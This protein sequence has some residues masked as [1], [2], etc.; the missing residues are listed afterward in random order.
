MRLKKIIALCLTALFL[1][2]APGCAS[3][4]EEDLQVPKQVSDYEVGGETPKKGGTLRLALAGAGSLN[5]ILAENEHTMQVLNLVYDSLFCRDA[6]EAL[7]PVLC[8]QYSVS[9]DGLTYEFT[10]RDGIG[11]HNGDTLSAQDVE[12]TIYMIL[13]SESLYKSKLSAISTC[14]SSGNTLYITLHNPVVNFPALLD[15]P[16]LS[17]EDISV[18]DSLTYVPNGTGRYKVQ[19]YKKSKELYLSVNENYFR[20]FSPYIENIAVYLLK[21]AGAAVTMLENMQID[22]LSSHV[23]NLHAYTP[24]RNL[25]SV[26]H[27]SGRFTF[28]GINNQKQALLSAKTRQVLSMAL[29]RREI[30]SGSTVPY[31]TAAEIP[32]PDQSF[33][34]SGTTSMEKPDIQRVK[35]MLSEDGWTDSDANGVPEKEVYGEQVMLAPG[36][37]V[38]SENPTR[39]KI[40]EQVKTFWNAAGIP[41]YVAVVP[42][43]EYQSRIASGEYDVFIGSVSLSENYDVSFLLKT[44]ANPLGVSSE[45]IDRTLNT[46]AISNQEAYKQA[47]FYELCNALRSEMPLVGLFFENDVIVFDSRVKGNIKPSGSDM[48]YSIDQWFL[49]E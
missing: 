1:C 34:N 19:S 25:S 16:V 12:A 22:V 47:Q 28:V 48:F 36:I 2:L 33:W 9:A 39:L 35:T 42:Y 32:V 41:A 18:Y 6:N 40:A 10:I 24:K 49:S 43:E 31:G 13:S 46:L 38:N 4:V 29:D 30:L 23:I 26:E 17:D 15:F 8:S 5:P 3:N 44:N 7:V 27:T 11:F 21:D 20:N 45:V 14:S 37:L